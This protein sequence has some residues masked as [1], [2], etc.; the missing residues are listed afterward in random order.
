MAS[1][2]SLPLINM[3]TSSARDLQCLEGIGP[4][5]AERI[6]ELRNGGGGECHH[7]R[8]CSCQWQAMR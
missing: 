2:G 8:A 1:G 7:G 4:K 6:I 5:W 3:F